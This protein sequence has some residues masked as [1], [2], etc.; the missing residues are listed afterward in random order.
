ME[1]AYILFEVTR[2]SEHSDKRVEDW[3]CRLTKNPKTGEPYHWVGKDQ[4]LA[5]IAKGYVVKSV[6]GDWPSPEQHPQY[7]E[8]LDIVGPLARSKAEVE[9][10]GN[11]RHK[12]GLHNGSGAQQSA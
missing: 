7:K 12:Q 8:V 4:I 9:S 10:G 2:D 3:Q 1:P 5:Y 11:K 6:G